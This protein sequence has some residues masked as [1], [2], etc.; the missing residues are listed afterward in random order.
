MASINFAWSAVWHDAYSAVWFSTVLLYAMF[1]C[2]LLACY[3]LG[4]PQFIC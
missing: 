1:V 4:V 3:L 2:C